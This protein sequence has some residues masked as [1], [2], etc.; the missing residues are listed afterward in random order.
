MRMRKF[1]FF[2]TAGAGL[3]ITAVIFFAGCVTNPNRYDAQPFSA[4]GTNADIYIFAP[5]AGNEALL[6]TLFTA[7]VSKKTAEPYLKRTSTLY[8]GAKYGGMVPEVTVVSAGSYPV[9]LSGLLFSKKDGWEKRRNEYSGKGSYYHSKTADIVLQSKTAF[10]L[11]GSSTRNTDNFLLRLSEPK[12]PA[13]PDRFQ[14]MVEAGGTGEIG[15]YAPSGSRIISAL[16]GLQDIDLPLRSIELYLKKNTDT[17]YRYAAIFDVVNA[18]AA[19][20]LRTLLGTVLKGTLSVQGSS[21]FVENA[22]IS[23]VELISLFRSLIS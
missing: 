18:R 7:F 20:V 2:R 21:I 14:T 17:T 19:V 11:L 16:F 12:Q 8:I 6:K 9:S 13:F 5:I 3:A 22:D 10:A 4:V 1:D 15:I 23:E